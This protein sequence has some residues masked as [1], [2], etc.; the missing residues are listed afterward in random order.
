[1]IPLSFAQLCEQ[2][3]FLPHAD[4]LDYRWERYSSL[5]NAIQENEGGL[6]KFSQVGSC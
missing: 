2:L 5:K 4:H 1:M 3:I 6:D